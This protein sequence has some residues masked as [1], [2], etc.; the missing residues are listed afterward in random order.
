MTD[1]LGLRIKS[2]YEDKTRF[3]LMRRCPTIMRLDGKAFHTYCRGLDKPFDEGL[4][5]DMQE[6]MKFLCK[7]IQGCKLGYCQSDEI[8]LLLTDYDTIE[9]A[10]WFDYNLQKMCSVSSSMAT[11]EFNKL[12]AIR[13]LSTIR[14]SENDV[15]R[16]EIKRVLGK[17]ANFDSRVFQ[18]ADY[19]EVVNYFIWRYFDAVRNSIQMLAQYHFSQRDL[20]GENTTIL[21]Q[22]LSDKGIFWEELHWSKKGGSLCIYNNQQWNIIERPDNETFRKLVYPLLQRKD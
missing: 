9:T 7:E 15:V 19:E 14:L 3:K 13:N 12:R 8:S 17:T 21:Q 2:Q 1:K 18:I 10:A 6:T 16:E 4:I 5:Q 20:H 22:M 11:S